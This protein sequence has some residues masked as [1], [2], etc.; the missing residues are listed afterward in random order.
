MSFNLIHQDLIEAQKCIYEPHGF[1]LKNVQQ[2]VENQEYGACIFE[3]AGKNVKF[4]VAKITPTK[5]GQF[6]TFYKREQRKIIP[7]DLSDAFDILI[8]SVR[9][10]HGFGQF[11]FPKNVLYEKGFLSKNG[12]DGKRAMR[13]YPSWDLVN[14]QQ[15]KKTQLWQLLYF[16]QIDLHKNSDLK[17]IRV[18]LG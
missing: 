11:V 14:N 3:L 9:S 8:V 10:E 1:I 12:V 16:V 6:V 17:K 4:R 2:E 13:V 7:Y 5:I 15:A 18:L